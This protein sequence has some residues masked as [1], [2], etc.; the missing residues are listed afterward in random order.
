MNEMKPSE[1]NEIYTSYNV[2][3][4]CMLSHV[5]TLLSSK[6]GSM[7]GQSSTNPSHLPNFSAYFS[8]KYFYFVTSCQIKYGRCNNPLPG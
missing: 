8:L 4:S 7:V 3:T 5:M 1:P 2:S 6:R